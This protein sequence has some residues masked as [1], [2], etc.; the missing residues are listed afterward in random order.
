MKSLAA[1]SLLFFLPSI[2]AAALP[3]LVGNELQSTSKRDASGNLASRSPQSGEILPAASRSM[4]DNPSLD[5]ALN[6]ERDLSGRSPQGPD[7]NPGEFTGVDLSRYNPANRHHDPSSFGEGPKN[8]EAEKERHRHHNGTHWNSTD[9][10]HRKQEGILT[11]LNAHGEHIV[12]YNGTHF[13]NGTHYHPANETVGGG[14][15]LGDV[16]VAGDEVA[17]YRQPWNETRHHR[18]HPE[19]SD[20]GF[21]LPSGTGW[22]PRPSGQ[23]RHHRKV[24]SPAEAGFRGPKSEKWRVAG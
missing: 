17:V 18:H 15:L 9:L 3:H 6:V 19:D 1:F 23:P 16:V 2:H 4:T 12:V 5:P 20:G 22:I 24:P 21:W 10:E 7:S 11:E 14:P 8:H 13:A